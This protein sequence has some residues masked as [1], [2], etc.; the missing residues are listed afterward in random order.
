MNDMIFDEYQNCVND[1][2]I[3]HNNI[4][5]VITKYSETNSRVN[6]AIVK[7]ITSCECINIHKS[8]NLKKQNEASNKINTSDNIPNYPPCDDCRNIIEKEISDNLFYLTSLC[9]L[10]G[11][12]L[13]DIIIKE[14]DKLLTLGK[15]N[16][17]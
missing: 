4:L 17:N 5:D 9:N 14:Y 8:F 13:Y 12:S 10:L 15:F 7:S 6:R 1:C 3:R 11:I 2:L 16:L